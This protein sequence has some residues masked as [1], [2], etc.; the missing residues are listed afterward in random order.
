MKPI[1]R[2][3]IVN[4]FTLME[5]LIG[6]LLLGVVV[7]ISF[8]AISGFQ[9]NLFRFQKTSSK[10]N[11]IVQMKEVIKYDFLSA[12]QI[13]RTQNGFSL[14]TP[15][16]AIDYLVHDQKLIRTKDQIEMDFPLS[17]HS[18]KTYFKDDIQ[19]IPNQYVD[20]LK[21]EIKANK[22]IILFI[23]KRPTL[24][25]SINQEIFQDGN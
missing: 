11:E 23:Q 19:L 6:M 4:A 8:T 9:S 20:A 16:G 1:C 13:K 14:E 2:N 17:I 10:L 25:E 18:L 12:N 24:V 21:V 7:S 15:D 22:P 3:H 5:V